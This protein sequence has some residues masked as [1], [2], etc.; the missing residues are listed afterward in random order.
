[1][2]MTKDL[3]HESALVLRDTKV[4][5]RTDVMVERAPH[6]TAHAL[7]LTEVADYNA[8]M[9]CFREAQCLELSQCYTEANNWFKRALTLRYRHPTPVMHARCDACLGNDAGA[10]FWCQTGGMLDNAPETPGLLA[11]TS[12]CKTVPIKL[13]RCSVHF[14]RASPT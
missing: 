2:V 8:A 3:L 9:S 6:A 4:L 13:V 14:L 11:C 12:N 1:M 7:H 10:Q 5:L